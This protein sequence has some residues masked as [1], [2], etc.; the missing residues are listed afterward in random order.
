MVFKGCRSLPKRE[1]GRRSI[2]FSLSGLEDNSGPWSP[3]PNESA[4]AGTSSSLPLM[5]LG[6][7]IEF[8]RLV[9]RTFRMEGFGGVK[10][11]TVSD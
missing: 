7:A 9:S 1:R 2:Y 10:S 11:K 5:K 6:G 3:G 8:N 4:M